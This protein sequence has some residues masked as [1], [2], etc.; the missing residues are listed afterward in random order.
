MVLDRLLLHPV[1]VHVDGLE[2]SLGHILFDGSGQLGNEEGQ[3]D[4][5]LLPLGIRIGQNRRQE[6]IGPQK[7]LHLALEIHLLVLIQVLPVDRHAGIQ[8][9]VEPVA[10][11][12]GEVALDEIIYLLQVVDLKAVERRLEVVQP[13]GIGL[14]GEHRGPVVVGKGLLYRV[15]VIDEVEHKGVMLLGVRPVET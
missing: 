1:A 5:E 12:P 14:L 11:G 15:G 3:E 2:N 9:R 8:D 6:S 10:V 13:V 4:R 7:R